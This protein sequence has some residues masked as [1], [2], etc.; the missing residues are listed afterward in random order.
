MLS[1]IIVLAAVWLAIPVGFAGANCG[2][3]SSCPLEE[4]DSHRD[5]RF[6][7]DVSH[8]YVDQDQPMVGTDEAAIGAIPQ[9][10]DE[11]RTVN[12]ITNIRATVRNRRGWSV[13][14]TLPY[15]RRTHEHIH[16]DGSEDHYERWHDRGLGDLDVSA[17]RVFRGMRGPQW[18]L[19]IG[20]KTP[21]GKQKGALTEDGDPIEASARL[22]TGSW[23]LTA[24]AGAEWSLRAPGKDPGTS[25]PFR[26][27]IS[28]RANGRGVENYRH[29]AELQ[30]HA[31]TEYALSGGLAALLQTNYRVRAKDDVG[32]AEEEDAA[33]TGG[34]ALYLTPGLRVD[35]I[36]DLSLYGLVQI[37]V[38]ERV[39]GIQIVAKTNLII[40]VSRS[41]F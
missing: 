11:V 21:T 31:S 23:D 9:D 33:N 6:R 40:G 12:R 15:L 39:N 13:A 5:A 37:P 34:A 36:S 24:S 30:A 19:G 1:R 26:L 20:V 16:H 27:S 25:M 41:V 4:P 38:W 10:H 2:S 3:E 32:D 22:G 14:A 28:G 8:L 18:R 7:I 35:P 29:G 17:T